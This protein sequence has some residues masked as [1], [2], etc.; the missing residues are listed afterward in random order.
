MYMYV[1]TFYNNLD[2]FNINMICYLY[3]PRSL[4]KVL[5]TFVQKKIWTSWNDQFRLSISKTSLCSQYSHAWIH[6]SSMS[7]QRGTENINRTVCLHFYS[8]KSELNLRK[9]CKLPKNDLKLAVYLIY[10]W[11]VHWFIFSE[12]FLDS[13]LFYFRLYWTVFRGNSVR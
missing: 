4:T 9:I 3:F 2:Q 7:G 5:K 13:V 6:H 10:L 12:D 11:L 1:R 8:L